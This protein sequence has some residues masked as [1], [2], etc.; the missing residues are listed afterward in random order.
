MGSN[1]PRPEDIQGYMPR[2]GRDEASGEHCYLQNGVIYI[3]GV[4]FTPAPDIASFKAFRGNFAR[5][6]NYCY[7]GM[8]RLKGANPMTFTMLN[9]TWATDRQTVWCMGGTVADAAGETFEACDDG[10]YEAIDRHPSSYGKDLHRVFQYDADGKACW[11]RKADPSSFEAISAGEFGRDAH[12]V[13]CGSSV[14]PKARRDHWQYMGNNYSKDDR[15]VFYF[16]R[17]VEGA[18]IESFQVSERQSIVCCPS[19]RDKQKYYRW[20]REV[21]REEYEKELSDA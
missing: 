8:R 20:E 13:F 4:Q 14:I 6:R 21:S 1:R 18:D 2:E 15:R 5:D 16:N 7:H 9:F 19:A 10:H 11:V 17:V 12:F 3:A